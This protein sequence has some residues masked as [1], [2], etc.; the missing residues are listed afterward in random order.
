MRFKWFLS[1]I[2]A[3]CV[4]AAAPAR[5]EKTSVEVLGLDQL[6][7]DMTLVVGQVATVLR[8]EEPDETL[9]VFMTEEALSGL[10]MFGTLSYKGFA[11]ASIAMLESALIEVEPAKMRGDFTLIFMDGLGRRATAGIVAEYAIY[12]SGILIESAKAAPVFPAS[13]ESELH[14]VPAEVVPDDLPT[15]MT[16]HASLLEWLRS[17]AVVPGASGGDYFVFACLTEEVEADA[18]LSLL[19]SSTSKGTQGR[20]L[21]AQTLYDEGWLVSVGRLDIGGKRA[22]G[23]FIKLVF[24]GGAH[25]PAELREPRLIGAFPLQP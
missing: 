22:S 10:T 2:V 21:P 17:N 3:F 8:G 12:P 4:A 19:M 11:V 16:D 14:Y 1:I 24:G 25:K 5:A 7:P 23:Q 9:P 15:R 13:P 6:P 20:Y 18:V